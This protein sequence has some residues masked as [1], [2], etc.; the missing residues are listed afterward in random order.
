MSSSRRLRFAFAAVLAATLVPATSAA[1]PGPLTT[2]ERS[3]LERGRIVRRPLPDN[4]RG[5]VGGT[6]WI[7]VDAPIATV[8]RT[9]SSLPAYRLMFP[10]TDRIQLLEQEGA[11][12]LVRIEQEETVATFTWVVAVA[13]DERR[14]ELRFRLDRNHRHVVDDG[15]GYVKLAPHGAAGDRTLVTFGAVVDPGDDAL[16]QDLLDD[17]AERRMLGMPRRLKRQIE[18][19][20]LPRPAPVRRAE[21]VVP[22]TAR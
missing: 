4:R 13:V 14:H 10:R 22:R 15:W 1:R 7:V 16:V 12:R 6:S 3:R 11:R 8:W 9:L 5:L 20:R 2:A 17:R 21:V 19:V 18:S